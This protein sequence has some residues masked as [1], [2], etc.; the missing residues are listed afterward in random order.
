V[1]GNLVSVPVKITGPVEDAKI[2]FFSPS[3]VGEELLGIV[4]RTFKLPVTLV[5]PLLPG[6]EKH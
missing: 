4:K 6:E 3:A 2:T 5:E 1:G